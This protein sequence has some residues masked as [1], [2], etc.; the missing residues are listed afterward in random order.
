MPKNPENKCSYQYKTTF[1]LF[2]EFIS[3]FEIKINNKQQ[4]IDFLKNGIISGVIF[5][6]K[7]F[8][9]F[10][11]RKYLILH[12]IIKKKRENISTFIFSPQKN[13]ILIATKNNKIL[14]FGKKYTWKKKFH[15]KD[16]FLQLLTIVP[17]V[18]NG[19]ITNLE[20]NLSENIFLIIYQTRIIEL[21]DLKGKIQLIFNLKYLPK[22]IYFHSNNLTCEKIYGNNDHNFFF[23]IDLFKKKIKYYKKLENFYFYKK[24]HLFKNNNIVNFSCFCFQNINIKNKFQ[25]LDKNFCFLNEN[26]ILNY[27]KRNFYLF[28][29]F[30]NI[31]LKTLIYICLSGFKLKNSILLSKIEPNISNPINFWLKFCQGDQSLEFLKPLSEKHNIFIRSDYHLNHLQEIYEIKFFGKKNFFVVISKSNAIS[32]ITRKNFLLKTKFESKNGFFISIRIKGSFLIGMNNFSQFFFWDISLLK[33]YFCFF[34]F[35]NISSVF[36]FVK[37]NK[38]KGII[39]AA[40]KNGIIKNWKIKFE[41][42]LKLNVEFL[43]SKN[44]NKKQIN[45][46]IL[47]PK[48]KF[49]AGAS[50]KKEILFW[51]FS[52]KLPYLVLGKFERC[53]WS[54]DFSSLNHSIIAGSGN[55]IIFLF[56]IIKGKC[57]YKLQGHFSPV[58]CCKFSS[59][60]L[61]IFSSGL[62]GKIKIWKISNGLCINTVLN[63]QENVWSFDVS[64]DS[65]FIIS[66]CLKGKIV[67]LKD[68]G[69]EFSRLKIKN[70]GF[71]FLLQKNLYN[72][73]LRNFFIEMYEKICYFHDPVLL[74]DFFFFIF[75]NF[76]GN[77]IKKIFTFF[78][79]IDNEKLNFLFRSILIWH[80]NGYKGMMVQNI[81]FLIFTSIPLVFLEKIDSKIVKSL[82]PITL[83]S[84][85][86]I[87]K[88]KKIEIK[89]DY[90]FNLYKTDYVRKKSKNFYKR[91]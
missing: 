90:P 57:L 41:K 10:K 62:D 67:I 49:L 56:D 61:H 25:L 44:K 81:L 39:S 9:F 55:G 6:N 19:N 26:K 48:G 59:D 11:I 46:L 63:H 45:F 32:I 34:A 36:S 17:D 38:I 20:F 82:I 87:K 86:K 78:L 23:E 3:Y 1:R 74:Y 91:L 68:F 21:F 30:S 16:K 73:N 24:F 47:S 72:N 79:K 76:N 53:I 50:L 80:F 52:Q 89:K 13:K 12:Q 33:L 5:S 84:Y 88:N 69:L 83:K 71:F 22:D 60:D 54:L 43:D 2:S 42:N 77:V 85:E 64:N 28:N 70:L 14:L 4:N 18:K 27:E 31:I 8:I 65:R 51:R 7:L 15:N 75:N 37:I 29:I 58:L 35:K 66:A 40:G